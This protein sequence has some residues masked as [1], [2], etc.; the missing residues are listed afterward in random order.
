MQVL[1]F[2]SDSHWKNIMILPH[3]SPYGQSSKTK[4][5]MELA[6]VAH[7]RQSL[8]WCSLSHS[9]GN[10]PH[11][12]FLTDSTMALTSVSRFWSTISSSWRTHEALPNCACIFCCS[13]FNFSVRRSPS[14][15]MSSVARL[16]VMCWVNILS[17]SN[18]SDED[19]SMFPKGLD[20]SSLNI[21]F[22]I[23]FIIIFLNISFCWTCCCP[24]RTSCIAG[25]STPP[26]IC[27]ML[28][29]APN[30]LNL[31]QVLVAIEHGVNKSVWGFVH[32]KI[33]FRHVL[34]CTFS[35]SLLHFEQGGFHHVF[36]E[37]RFHGL[38][39][40][41]L[42]LLF[43]HSKHVFASEGHADANQNNEGSHDVLVVCLL[44]NIFGR[45]IRWATRIR[46]QYL[47]G[48]PSST[49]P[50]PAFIP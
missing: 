13:D 25:R 29:K 44:Y 22:N 4:S 23:I 48:S 32:W 17:M 46:Q 38:V 33:E 15:K 6:K 39:F 41:P 45:M 21:F 40:S 11:S 28:F 36:S 20:E 34:S 2:C 26:D 8:M 16:F 10:S 9:S 27:C 31:F 37:A 19:E 49:T 43:L 50:C 14:S 5:G 1:Y 30:T 12:P 42:L 3:F 47:L 35:N 7:V 24:P 18:L